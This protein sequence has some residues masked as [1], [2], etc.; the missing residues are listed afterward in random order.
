MFPY[1]AKEI[2]DLWTPSEA[3]PAETICDIIFGEKVIQ[4]TEPD[5]EL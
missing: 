3:N 1:D 4:L 2:W 5:V